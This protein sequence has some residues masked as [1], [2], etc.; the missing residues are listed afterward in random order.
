MKSFKSFLY[1]EFLVVRL[2]QLFW[3]AQPDEPANFVCKKYFNFCRPG[4]P[5]DNLCQFGH[6]LCNLVF[7]TT[8]LF[9]LVPYFVEAGLSC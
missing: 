7:E 5:F 3:E 6:I 9:S 1:S 4:Y 8:K 2:K